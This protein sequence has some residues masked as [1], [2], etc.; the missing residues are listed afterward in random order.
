MALLAAW[1]NLGSDLDVLSSHLRDFAAGKPR[2]TSASEFSLLDECLLDGLLSRVWQAWCI[3][4]RA[5]VV[6]SCIGT[7][8]A[9]GVLIGGLPQAVTEEHVSGATIV[10]RKKRATANYWVRTNSV[11][12]NEPTWG[13]VDILVRLV[14]RLRP[15]NHARL[16]AGFSQS[17]GSA[18]ALQRIRNGSAHTNTQTIAEIESL[19]SSYIVFPIAHPVHALFWIHPGS[20]DY[21]ATTAI[22][23][24]KD[25]ALAAIS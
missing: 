20:R 11:L 4:C 14:S 7:V 24:L 21:L 8:D 23:E 5:S 16:S 9:S 19:R 1:S 15:H 3:F 18:N 25:A 13:D 17:H 22:Q 6:H 12:R 10:A 2:L